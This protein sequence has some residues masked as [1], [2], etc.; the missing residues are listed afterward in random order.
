MQTRKTYDAL[1][2]ANR[3]LDLSEP[4]G[5]LTPMQVIKL[6]YFCHAWMLGLHGRPLL[7]TE[8]EAW[9][10]GPVIPSVYRAFKRY[11]DKKI[12]VC[13]NA[14][15]VRFEYDKDADSI[16]RQVFDRYGGCDGPKLSNLTHAKDSPWDLVWSSKQR[17]TKIPN[18]VIRKYYAAKIRGH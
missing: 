14:P 2:V 13:A 17:N 9:Q 11:R 3:L 6:T 4:S 16:I 10:Y 8:V 12:R 15:A 1:S 7:N 18:D 5:G